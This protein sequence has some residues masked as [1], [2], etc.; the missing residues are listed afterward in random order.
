MLNKR[1]IK[2]M[3]MFMERTQNTTNSLHL[4]LMQ[5]IFNSETRAHVQ[6]NDKKWHSN[7]FKS[8]TIFI[9][10]LRT[11]S[12]GVAKPHA[13]QRTRA[14]QDVQVHARVCVY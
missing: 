4:D 1:W 10:S 2:M 12:A 9:N 5:S 7:T 6:Q 8:T 14:S 3:M 11:Q 13:Y